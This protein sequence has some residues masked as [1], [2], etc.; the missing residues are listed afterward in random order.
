ML[1]VEDTNMSATLTCMFI[2]HLSRPIQLPLHNL[3]SPPSFLSYHP[4]MFSIPKYTTLSTCSDSSTAM[5]L[6]MMLSA[7]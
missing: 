6:R 1:T 5:H 2:T 3:P 4:Y 7:P